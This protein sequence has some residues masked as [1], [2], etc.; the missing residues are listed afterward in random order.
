[1]HRVEAE[2]EVCGEC[3]VFNICG[4]YAYDKYM[5]GGEV[6]GECRRY[7]PSLDRHLPLFPHV[8]STDVACGEAL[9]A[10]KGESRGP[11]A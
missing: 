11:I 6:E 9:G 8:L 2:P 5:G 1:M 7:A 10:L 3:R 4:W